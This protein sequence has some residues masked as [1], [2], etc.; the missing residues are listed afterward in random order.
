MNEQQAPAGWYDDPAGGGGVRYWNGSAWTLEVRAGANTAQQREP[1]RTDGDDRV[2]DGYMSLNGVRVPIGSTSTSSHLSSGP[3]AASSPSASGRMQTLR[4][5]VGI[6][7][8]VVLIVAFFIAAFQDT[9]PDHAYYL[10]VE[11]SNGGGIDIRWTD[12]GTWNE[13]QGVES[14]WRIGLSDPATG[15]M[16]LLRA[17]A[18]NPNERATCR[19]L[20][21]DDMVLDEPNA[22]VRGVTSM[23]S[24]FIPSDEE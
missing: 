18:E 20:D 19:I 12:D 7:G 23:C 24:Y 3:N 8:L 22:V 1:D 21:Q 5:M 6:I 11:S 9:T 17:T 14:G 4:T 2:P 10:E 15:R 13:E 16:L